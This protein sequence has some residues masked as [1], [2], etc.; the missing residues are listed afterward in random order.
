MVFAR[1]YTTGCAARDF[2]L[3]ILSVPD[4]TVSNLAASNIRATVV[5]P[6]IPIKMACDIA[7]TVP[8]ELTNNRKGVSGGNQLA[9]E[10]PSAGAV[11]AKKNAP[12]K[13]RNSGRAR[14]WAEAASR[15]ME[16]KTSVA[17]P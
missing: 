17:A 15:A 8:G 13:T 16:P 14:F 2:N 5:R 1:N 10:N 3:K 4:P 6:I 9:Q 7:A 12:S 11:S